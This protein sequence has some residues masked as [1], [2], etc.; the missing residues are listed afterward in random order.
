VALLVDCEIE[1]GHEL[2]DLV[3]IVLERDGEVA[4]VGLVGD[5]A[6]E[7]ELIGGGEGKAGFVGVAV[8]VVGLYAVEAAGDGE[9]E[10][11]EDDAADVGRADVEPA[12]VGEIFE[13]LAELGGWNWAASLRKGSYVPAE[14]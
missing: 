11:G 5:E 7:G 10:P 1:V 14:K 8:D 12:L 3:K 4:L 6:V 13:W 9:V 2:R